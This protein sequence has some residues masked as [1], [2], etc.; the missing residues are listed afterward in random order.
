MQEINRLSPSSIGMP[1]TFSCA[2]GN[3][4][5]PAPGVRML[6]CTTEAATDC[7]SRKLLYDRAMIFQ[8]LRH[9][10]GSCAS[11][12]LVGAG[13]LRARLLGCKMQGSVE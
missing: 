5:K 12:L 13:I 4:G 8:D 1:P 2:R 10:G 7:S 9:E 11:A 6:S 3:N